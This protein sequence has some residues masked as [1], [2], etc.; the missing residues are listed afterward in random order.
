MVHAGDQLRGSLIRANCFPPPPP[1]LHM[2]TKCSLGGTCEYMTDGK[3][4][5]SSTSSACQMWWGFNS[6]SQ[7]RGFPLKVSSWRPLS[8]R[9]ALPLSYLWIL[10][11]FTEFTENNLSSCLP[12]LASVDFAYEINA[13]LWQTGSA[14]CWQ[15][16][17][18]PFLNKDFP[19]QLLPALSG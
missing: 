8:L 16:F 10:F 13:L 19:L 1:S 9:N 12:F 17:S 2:F 18:F 6:D 7:K 5:H 14:W 3:C 4:L 11:G 15:K